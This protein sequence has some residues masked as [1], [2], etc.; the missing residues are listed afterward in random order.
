[1]ETLGW[2]ALFDT[3]VELVISQGSDMDLSM[4]WSVD[5]TPVDFTG[6]DARAQLRKKPG[7]PLWLSLTTTEDEH[8]NVI[9]LDD[10]GMIHLHIDDEETSQEAW[11]ASSRKEGRW[12]LEVI[13]PDGSPRRLVMGPVRVSR[14]VTV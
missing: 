12:D 1:M 13:D 8:G 2:E 6:W 10:D 3:E 7:G 5:G 11:N 14:E 4:Q 9:M